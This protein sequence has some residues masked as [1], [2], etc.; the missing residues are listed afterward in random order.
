[1][2]TIKIGENIAHLRKE[3]RLT[4]DEL[5]KVLRV[6]NQAIS[7]WEAGKCYP[8][9][10]LIPQLANFFGV[11]IDMLL[12]GECSTKTKPAKEATP[13]IIL[14]AMKIAQEDQ[15]VSTAVLQRKLRI[16]YRKAKEIIKDMY[17]DGYIIKDA[18]CEYE[19]RYLYNRDCVG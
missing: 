7:K 17:E 4:Q 14:Q 6:S 12:L 15:C 2:M 5:A 8:D 16:S 19:Y 11:S 1:M 10:E 13:S 9:I 18:N 3:K